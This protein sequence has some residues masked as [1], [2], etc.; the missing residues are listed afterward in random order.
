MDID[1]ILTVD[2]KEQLV[3]INRNEL[4]FE[5]KEYQQVIARVKQIGEKRILDVILA[6][7]YVYTDD[8]L[9]FSFLQKYYVFTLM[10]LY[11]HDWKKNKRR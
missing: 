3:T 11:Y 2:N 6:P 5:P 10:K 8:D 1:I 4:N 7:T 9:R